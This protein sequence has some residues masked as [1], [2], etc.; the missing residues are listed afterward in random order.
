MKKNTII[1]GIAASEHLD[2]SGE[3][4]SIEGM[5]I[6][7]LGGPDSILNWEHGSKDRPSQVVGKVTF[8]KKIMKKDGAKT[9]REKYFWNKIKKP[10][11]YIKAELFDGIGHSGA[12]DVAAML[13]YKNK[14]K[15]EESRLVV[16]FSIEGGKMDKKGMVVTKSIARDVAI[17][18][19]PC[20]KVCDAELIEDNDDEDFLYKNQDFDCEILEKGSVKI[21]TSAYRDLIL[22]DIKKST[23]GNTTKR[24]FSSGEEPETLRTGDKILHNKTGSMRTGKDIYNDPKTWESPEKKKPYGTE[25][26]MRK[27]LIAGMMAG[28]PDSLSGGAALAAEELVPEMQNVSVPS[29]KK[30][31]KLKKSETIKPVKFTNSTTGMSSYDDIMADPEHYGKNKGIFHEV[32][33]MHPE[34]YINTVATDYYNKTKGGKFELPSVEHAKQKLIE[35]RR[36]SKNMQKVK[37]FDVLHMPILDHSQNTL[38]QEGLHRAVH[39]LDGNVQQMPVMVVKNK[40]D[41]IKK[42]E[43]GEDLFLQHYSTKQGLKSIDPNHMG[44]GVDKRTQG[45]S[46]DHKFSFYYPH[47]YENPEHQVKS[48]AKSKYTVKVPRGHKIYDSNVHGSDMI[49]Q[50]KAKNQGIFTM[51]HFLGTLKENGYHGFKSN[52][53]GIKMVG[54]FNDLPIHSEEEANPPVSIKKNEKLEKMA[55]PHMSNKEMGL[56]QDPRMDVKTI[57]PEKTYTTKAGK[58]VTAPQLETKKIQQQYRNKEKEVS[59]LKPGYEFTPKAQKEMSDYQEGFGLDPDTAAG[60]NVYDPD[61]GINNSYV[62]KKDAG[63]TNINKPSNVKNAQ[64]KANSKKGE[65]GPEIHEATHGFFSDISSK[66][67]E[68][69]SNQLSSHLLN[70]YFDP[71]DLEKIKDFVSSRYGEDYPHH[72]EEHITHIADILNRPSVRKEFLD[73]N[74]NLKKLGPNAS[75]EDKKLA[76]DLDRRTYKRLASGW[77]NSVKFVKDSNNLSSFLSSKPKKR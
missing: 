75:D 74:S 33:N 55:R 15:G 24:I 59:E 76:Q 57:D 19:K 36:N 68:E 47:N 21:N 42:S 66:H 58:Q 30:G 37:G 45:R 29:K 28:S 69:K 73:Q 60:E 52:P 41:E 13:R 49:N 2:S 64:S 53:N 35:D 50:A 17:T 16:G 7:S 4:L 54:M 6:S 9:K 40:M 63:K 72:K 77:N 43:D 32:K 67:G 62:Y 61:Y 31:K 1:D 34:E 26:S 20:N 38:F 71:K 22:S 3:S 44:S 14:D 51:D 27:A 65:L 10:F 8:A 11:V 48:N 12:Q 39:A 23:V 46:T 18:V 25:N 56:G 5:D 70:E